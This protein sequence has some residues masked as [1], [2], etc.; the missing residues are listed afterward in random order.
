MLI[1]TAKSEN[2]NALVLFTGNKFQKKRKDN[3]KKWK[4]ICF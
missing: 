1:I 3:E 4:T 2:S